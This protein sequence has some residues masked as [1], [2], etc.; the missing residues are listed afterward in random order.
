MPAV[1]VAT[2]E[3]GYVR[4]HGRNAASWWL[5]GDSDRYDY[6]YRHRE[7]LSWIPRIREIA[8]HARNTFIVFNN[9]RRGH[10][11][12]N[13]ASMSKLL[14]RSKKRVGAE[15]NTRAG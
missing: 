10:A 13:A 7:L 3:T 12:A 15:A 5:R 11:L 14:A 4:F 9:H 8:R 1:A 2:S 6:R